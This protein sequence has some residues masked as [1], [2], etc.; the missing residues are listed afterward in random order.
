MC[1]NKSRHGIPSILMAASRA[2]ISASV[3]EWDTAPCFLHSHVIGRNELG[4]IS[5][6]K[7][8]VVDLLSVMS[9]AK[10]ASTNKISR[11]LS[12]VSPMKHF[13]V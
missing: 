8:P 13:C 1:V 3:D 6:R 5:I 9:V 7:A 12:G 10:L 2:T 11:S 4:P